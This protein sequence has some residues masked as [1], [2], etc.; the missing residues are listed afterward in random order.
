VVE[1]ALVPEDVPVLVPELVAALELELPLP[2]PLPVLVLEATLGPPEELPALEPE[3]AA[4][5]DVPLVVPAFPDEQAAK[6]SAL[7]AITP[8]RRTATWSPADFTSGGLYT[9][10]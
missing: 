1:P 2:L 8:L 5:D 10:S 4:L 7:S 9:E 6:A 3:A